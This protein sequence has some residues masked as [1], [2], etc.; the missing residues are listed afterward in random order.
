MAGAISGLALAHSLGA[1]KVNVEYALRRLSALLGH[2]HPDPLSSQVSRS[3]W[4]PDSTEEHITASRCRAL[5]LEVIRRAAHDWVLYRT[6]DRLHLRQ[7]AE[8][9]YI[10]LFEESPTHPWARIRVLS[11]NRLTSF[12]TICE[13]LDLDPEFVRERVRGMTVQQIMSAGRP[14]ECRKHYEEPCVEYS[15]EVDLDVLEHVDLYG[16]NMSY[17]SQL[18]AW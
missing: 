1:P 4:D 12:L 11:D 5:L 15:T 10:W 14:A 3:E 18:T 6:H 2:S 9:A 16:D 13:I 8:D 7:I 17:E